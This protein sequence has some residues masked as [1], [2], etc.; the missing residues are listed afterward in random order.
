MESGLG[1]QELGDPQHDYQPGP[2]WWY[3][4]ETRATAEFVSESGFN[5]LVD[6]LN[7]S[8]GKKSTDCPQSRGKRLT[9]SYGEEGSLYPNQLCQ[10]R[11]SNGLQIK[12]QLLQPE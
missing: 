11:Y 1:Q 7:A 9:D 10:A 2:Y 6:L 12:C 3:L 4:L 8:S 5:L